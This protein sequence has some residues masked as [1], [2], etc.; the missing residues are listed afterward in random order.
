M[1]RISAQAATSWQS[2]LV[3]DAVCCSYADVDSSV[4]R[5]HQRLLAASQIVFDVV[6][7]VPDFSSG[8]DDRDTILPAASLGFRRTVLDAAVAS[9]CA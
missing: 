8:G 9:S 4:P 6:V 7:F 5:A 1:R 2:I 3:V